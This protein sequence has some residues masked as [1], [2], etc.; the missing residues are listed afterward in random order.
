M[1]TTVGLHV[2]IMLMAL[3]VQLTD[4][5][6]SSVAWNA[7]TGRFTLDRLHMLPHSHVPHVTMIDANVPAFAVEAVAY[8]HVPPP[9]RLGPHKNILLVSMLRF[10][11]AYFNIS[12]T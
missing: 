3:F 9:P 10:A 5:V 12:S 11:R 1:G 8:F 4:T 6:P 2:I 7:H